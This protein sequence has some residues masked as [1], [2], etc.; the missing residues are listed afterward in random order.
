MKYYKLTEEGEK[1]YYDNE[2]VRFPDPDNPKQLLTVSVANHEIMLLAGWTPEEEPESSDAEKLAAAKAEKLMQIINYDASPNVE[3]FTINGT[4]MW[5]NHEVRQQIK[6]SVE[7]YVATGAE[8][9]TKIFDGV[10]YTFTCETWLQMLA[11]LEV[12]A[13]EALNATE[14]HKI[15][16]QQMTSIDD[17]EDYDYTNGYPAKLEFGE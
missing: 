13:A 7:A 3:Q 15:N 4:P 1:V 8:T 16:V 11:A 5:L 6:T 10:E 17:I 12:Y 9:V 2:P 14:R